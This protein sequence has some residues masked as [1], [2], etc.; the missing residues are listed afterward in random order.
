MSK[1]HGFPRY[2]SCSRK[3]NLVFRDEYERDL[4]PLCRERRLASSRTRRSASGFL[5][6]KYRPDAALPSSPRA[7]GIRD[8][9]MNERGF[10][11]LAAV[12]EVAGRLGATPA[13][14]ALAWIARR[15]GMTG[16]IASATTP[17]Q[18]TELIGGI[19]LK[20]DDEAVATLDKASAWQN[21][22]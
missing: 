13:Q 6:G 4:E 1:Q 18:L 19:D 14:V 17:E 2:E 15:P 10:G 5:S 22:A 21:Q 8:R 20:L 7:S 11:I 12:E 3:Y 16:P 9:Y